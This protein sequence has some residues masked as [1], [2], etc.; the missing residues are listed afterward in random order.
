MLKDKKITIQ[1]D[2]SDGTEERPVWEPL[3]G[4]ENIWAYYRAL[5]GKE[6][7]AAAKVQHEE[8]VLFVI[9]FHAGVKAGMLVQFKGKRY[10]I[11]R[12]DNFEGNKSDIKLYCK[13]YS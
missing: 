8:D 7:F 4:C 1:C 2:M 5:S 9:N 12:I 3:T 6:L 10:E 11:T 13:T